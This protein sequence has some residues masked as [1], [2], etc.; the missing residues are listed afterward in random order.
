MEQKAPI[1]PVG[2]LFIDR[3]L[4]E[5]YFTVKTKIGLKNG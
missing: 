5:I 4:D 2:I 3:R 1:S